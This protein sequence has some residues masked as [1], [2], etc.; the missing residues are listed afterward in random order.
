MNRLLIFVASLGLAVMTISATC[1]AEP[2]SLAG[3]SD[4]STVSTDEEG[5]AFYGSASLAPSL[6][7]SQEPL[8][9]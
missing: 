2:V 7:A 5:G 9:L 6:L 3:I 1:L 4:R 8:S